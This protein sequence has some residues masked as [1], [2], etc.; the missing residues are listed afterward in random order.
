MNSNSNLEFLGQHPGPFLL[1]DIGNSSVHLRALFRSENQEAIQKDDF[2]W[3]W[4]DD[5]F[6]ESVE[7]WIRCLMEYAGLELGPKSFFQVISCSVN[8][9]AREILEKALSPFEYSNNNPIVD[10]TFRD[11]DLEVQVDFPEKVGLDRL[12]AAFHVKESA[13]KKD[14]G[15]SFPGAVVVDAGTAV[16]IDFVDQHYKFQG[17]V[18]YPGIG[19]SSKALF[20]MTD[21]LPEIS[22]HTP[23]ELLKN[24]MGMPKAIGKNTQQAIEC[25]LFHSQLGGLLHT[26]DQIRKN[27]GGERHEEVQVWAAGGGI[28]LM[29]DFLPDGWLLQENLVLDGLETWLRNQIGNQWQK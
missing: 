19:L 12:V 17:G 27:G 15:N 21:A 9:P 18:I 2:W 11:F 24:G 29:G 16:T 1:A 20:Q 26:V 8:R 14:G 25:G 6:C 4:S 23:P 5:R 28:E 22:V 10:L 7:N 13:K 3:S